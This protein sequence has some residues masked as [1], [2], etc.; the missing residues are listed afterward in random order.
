[1]NVARSLTL[2]LL[3]L[4]LCQNVV[5]AGS[6]RRWR[7]L[8][9][10]SNVNIRFDDETM[11]DLQAQYISSNSPATASLATEPA[12]LEIQSAIATPYVTTESNAGW[13]L[14]A[15]TAVAP[16]PMPQPVVAP[17]APVYIAPAPAPAPA[18][19][20]A[21]IAPVYHPAHSENLAYDPL[22]KW[23]TAGQILP[24]AVE[25]HTSSPYQYDA[26]V[27]LGDS[28][29][30]S[31]DKLTTG[32]ARPWYESQVVHDLFGAT[33]DA[34]QR[35]DFSATVLSRVEDTFRNSGV[36]VELT[37]DPNASA[38][39]T[40]SV[41]SNTGFGAIPEAAGI[42]TM[43][44]DGFSFI[45]NMGHARSLDELQWAVA[46]NI[47]HELMHTFDVEHLDGTGEFLDAPIASWE[48]MIDPDTVFSQEAVAALASKDLRA[49]FDTGASF[50]GAQMLTQPQAVPEPATILLWTAAAA[51][52]G[53]YRWRNRNPAS[54]LSV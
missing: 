15:M 50:Y 11:E 28:G 38:A 12:P 2:G 18:P 1:M 10:T 14:A 6:L 36:H 51:G 26:F 23:S 53:L 30:A 43:G 40:L 8:W 13:N 44:G 16:Q 5:E 22:T 19:T 42:S 37:D 4:F 32:N 21:P 34:N 54:K 31:A 33:P 41:V 35:A 45:D 52:L 17:P 7:L 29:Y 49:R 48:T 9:Q 39:H 24:P 20:P 46:R 25:S 3:L 27:N 47:A